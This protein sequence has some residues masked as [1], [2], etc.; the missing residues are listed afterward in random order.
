M[1]AVVGDILI[2]LN[3]GDFAGVMDISYNACCLYDR[4]S[5]YWNYLFCR[6]KKNQ[7]N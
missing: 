2:R 3:K 7:I 5:Y 4:D 6:V 1:V